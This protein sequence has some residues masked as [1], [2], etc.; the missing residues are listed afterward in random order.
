[1]EWK[2]NERLLSIGRMAEITKY[3]Q[4]Y[5]VQKFTSFATDATFCKINAFHRISYDIFMFV[6]AFKQRSSFILV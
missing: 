1:M 4:F 5:N 3:F 6:H 2:K